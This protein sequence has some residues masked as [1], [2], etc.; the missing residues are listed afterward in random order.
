MK[1]WRKQRGVAA[2]EM[3]F[4]LIPMLI[5][6][7]GI[8]ELGRALYQYN[9]LVK[10]SRDAVRYL[11]QQDLSNLDE[12]TNPKLSEVREK[13]ISLAACGKLKCPDGDPLVAKVALCDYLNDAT[14]HKNIL[15]SEGTVDLVTVRIGSTC[16][17]KRDESTIVRFSSLISWVIS[18]I[19]FSTVKTTMASRYF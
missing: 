7:F 18:D 12:S 6:A 14:S 9:A 8:T 4:I 19:D 10:G 17:N 16:A 13:T 5:A 15:T 2:V 3:A 11:A 1:Y